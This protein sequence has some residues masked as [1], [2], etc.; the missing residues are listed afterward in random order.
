MIDQ[1]RHE[2]ARVLLEQAFTLTSLTNNPGQHASTL[3][4][5]GRLKIA[6]DDRAAARRHWQQAIDALEVQYDMLGGSAL[7]LA[8]FS[9]AYQALYR[10]LAQLHIDEGEYFEAIRLLESYR[11]RALLERIDVN[12]FLRRSE[13]GEQLLADLGKLQN[14]ARE[15]VT[16]DAASESGDA[17]PAE[18][19]AE[20]RRQRRDQVA[21]AVRQQPQL[22]ELLEGTGSPDSSMRVPGK[23]SRIL[24]YSL[25]EHRSDLLVISAE[26]ITAHRLPPAEEIATLVERFRILVQRPE[27]D[28]APLASVARNC[29]GC[30][31]PRR[32]PNSPARA[33]C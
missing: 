19:L 30:S 33:R 29:T 28:P 8:G 26:G 25:G 23:D 9:Q 12:R 2:E 22:A 17:T 6:Q 1:Q 31:W 3:F 13:V 14:R 15:A 21:A 24:Y 4:Q 10:S 27:A 18:R 16:P 7:T 5:M 20:L 32:K 11:N